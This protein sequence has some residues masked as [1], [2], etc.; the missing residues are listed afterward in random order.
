MATQNM[1]VISERM[2]HGCLLES[3]EGVH[4]RGAPLLVNGVLVEVADM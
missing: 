4:D 2:G 1:E 3:A